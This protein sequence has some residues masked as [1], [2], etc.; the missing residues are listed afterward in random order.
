MKVSCVNK[1]F[2]CFL[3]CGWNKL[4]SVPFRDVKVVL[5]CSKVYFWLL[6]L[7]YKYDGLKCTW[8]PSLMICC[9]EMHMHNYCCYA[10]WLHVYSNFCSVVWKT[11]S[12]SVSR[13][14]TTVIAS[15]STITKY[16]KGMSSHATDLVVHAKPSSFHYYFEQ[17]CTIN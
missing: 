10:Q 17:T 2:N 14:G 16:C 12:I 6:N 8:F 3:L 1:L 9:K 7:S 4:H 13:H 15:A 5:L 11:W